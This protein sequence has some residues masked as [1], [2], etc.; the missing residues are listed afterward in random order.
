[1]AF[2][3][4]QEVI[5]ASGGQLQ[6]PLAGLV[7]GGSLEIAQLEG[8]RPITV[9]LRGRAMPYQDPV[10]DGEQHTKRTFYPGNPVGTHQVLGPRETETTFQGMWKDR[11]IR[12]SILKNGDAG[13]V[14]SALDAVALFTE[15]YRSGK[16]VRVQWANIVRS[17]VIRKFTFTP[18]RVQDIAWDLDLEW[19]SRDDETAPRS[20]TE[21]SAPSG[22]DLLRRQDQLEDVAALAPPSAA[23]ELAGIIASINSIRDHVTAVVDNLRTVEAVV[24]APSAILGAIQ[25][26]VHGLV[27]Q[28]ED[29]RQRILGPRSSARDPQTSRRVKGDYT[30]PTASGRRGGAPPSS[31]SVQELQFEIW[32]R[33]LGS[34]AGGLSFQ[35]QRLL[36]D[37]LSRSQPKTT[38]VITARAG[39]TL[40]SIATRFY[41]SPDFANFLALTNRL[42]TAIVP[43][44]YQL[45]IPERPFGAS[46]NIE[47]LT[48]RQPAV[49]DGRCC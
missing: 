44:G 25:S 4:D 7:G 21:Q 45:R 40:Y 2:G 18:K 29:F 16:K 14:Q 9:L 32:C 1:M 19:S 5:A 6:D 13:A 41:G 48:D 15:L 36:L 47:P 11:F 28:L 8:D 46:A 24:N 49:G 42:T 38:R 22:Q 33:S 43:P 10:W 39:E 3:F 37:V 30:S 12:G 31:S 27:A 35:L 20:T 34:V 17:G 23:Q 26:G